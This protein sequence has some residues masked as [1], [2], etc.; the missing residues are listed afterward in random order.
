MTPN[1][2]PAAFPSHSVRQ[3]L[4][5]PPWEEMELGPDGSSFQPVLEAVKFLVLS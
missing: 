5:E 4:L 1:T 3:S 2:I